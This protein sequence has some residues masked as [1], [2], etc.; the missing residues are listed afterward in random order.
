MRQLEKRGQGIKYSSNEF[1]DAMRS[2]S[3]DIADSVGI[4]LAGR[5]GERNL[6]RNS[7]QYWRA[8]GLI[9]RIN[10]SGVIELTDFGRLVADHAVSQS[11]FAATTI[12]TLTLPNANIQSAEE[13][14]LWHRHGL[15]FKPLLLVLSILLELNARGQG[16]LTQRELTDIVIPL[17]GCNAQIADYANFVCW[18]REGSVD[19]GKF[20]NCCIESNDKRMAREFLLFLANYGYV[21][22]TAS[23]HNENER[24]AINGD[25]LDEIVDITSGMFKRNSL[26]ETAQTVRATSVTSEI[27]RK[28]LSGRPRQAQF[29][30]D[31]LSHCKRCV[32]TNVCMPE[33]LEAA[34]IKPYKYNGADTIANGFAMRTDIHLLFDTGHLRISEQ[35]DVELSQTARLDY[36]ALIPPR[37]AVPDFIDRENLRWRWENYNGY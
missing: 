12:I 14:E 8:L 13:C 11:E 30:R 3:A 36:G 9:P 4:D 21:N 18:A 2:L 32:I 28:R 24:Y 10:H 26:I 25:L 29:R 20:P 17:S 22:K 1:A 31:V 34:H 6:V 15:D 7:G 35:G 5:T 16:V 19:I 37:I 23:A 33:V 27:E